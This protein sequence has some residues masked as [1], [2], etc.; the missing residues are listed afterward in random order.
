MMSDMV[1][2]GV[3]SFSCLKDVTK[4]VNVC[5]VIQV[6]AAFPQCNGGKLQDAED[7]KGVFFVYCVLESK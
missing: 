5:D 2:D 1:L 6:L 3:T 7:F 4:N